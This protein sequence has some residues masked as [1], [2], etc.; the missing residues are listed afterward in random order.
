MQ[1][2]TKR[3]VGE[4]T[5]IYHLHGARRSI[6]NIGVG[7]REISIVRDRIVFPMSER[8]RNVW[9]AEWKP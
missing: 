2:E 1:P 9:M 3:P 5:A 7:F 6:T 8:M 4:A